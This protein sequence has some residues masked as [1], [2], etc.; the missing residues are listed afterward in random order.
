MAPASVETG[1]DSYRAQTQRYVYLLFA[2]QAIGASSPP[3]II[4]L[5]GLVGEALSNNKALSTLPVSLYNIGLALS[6]LPLGAL[7]AR[8]G[9]VNAYTLGALC[10][11]I[12]GIIATW[13]VINGSFVLFCLGC[14]MAGGYAA[15]VQSYRFAITDF[16]AKPEQPTAISR[17]MLGGLL[18]AVI[19]PQLVI[20]TQNLLPVP[21]SASFLG[22]SML[23]LI[24]LVFLWQMRRMTV[25]LAAQQS[26]LSG[27]IH[28]DEATSGGNIRSLGEIAGSFRFISTAVA[29]LV[30]YG[31]MTFMMTATPLAMIHHGHSLSTATLGI[32]WHILAM[33]APAFITGR[34]ISRFG[35]RNICIS[36][37]LLTACAAAISMIGTEVIWFW[38][39]LILLGVGWN[40]G[41]VSAT[42]M[43]STCYTHQE[44][45]KVQALNDTFVF[46]TTALA[47]LLSGQMMHILG[48]F[49]LNTLVFI[50]IV[51]ALGLLFIQGIAERRQ[52][53]KP[54]QE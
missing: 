4:S 30:S 13:G 54:A 6:V 45:L 16:V 3:I 38:G 19:G 25:K 12:G 44:R 53:D 10:A 32:Q 18:A 48:W 36:G 2:L 5:G 24:A 34:L 23:A 47:S 41:F 39:G 50:P 9:R 35:A 52:Q 20:W 43:L 26:A 27:P 22:Q 46:T 21:L 1:I 7:I 51:I 33:Y 11:F 29:A 42:V 17:V 15:C 28:H 49:W 37:L 40:L 14:L 31:L 8:Y